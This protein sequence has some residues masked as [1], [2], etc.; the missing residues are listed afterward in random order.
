MFVRFVRYLL[1]EFRWPLAVFTTLVVGGGSILYRFYDAGT[2]S[3]ARACHAVFLMIFLES[4]LDFPDEWYLQPMF[5]LFPV[6]GLGTIAD[7]IRSDSR[8]TLA[9][10]EVAL[11]S[12]MHVEDMG[13]KYLMFPVLKR[14]GIADE[15]IFE[16]V[17]EDERQWQGQAKTI[18]EKAK[19]KAEDES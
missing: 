14:G 12:V 17:K 15:Q 7:S 8:Q 1:Y 4:S 5:F 6:V 19:K 2:L 11:G 9:A 16:Y 13:E 10:L 3:F 18:I